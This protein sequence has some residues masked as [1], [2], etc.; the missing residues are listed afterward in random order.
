MFV[1][2]YDFINSM[3]V[4]WCIEEHHVFVLHNAFT[5]LPIRSLSLLS[6]PSVMVVFF[7]CNK[8]YNGVRFNE[9][10]IFIISN[11][12]GYTLVNEWVLTVT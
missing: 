6:C 12:R 11:S 5:A 1:Y 4:T 10:I 8:D 9:V 2:L 3:S 7:P